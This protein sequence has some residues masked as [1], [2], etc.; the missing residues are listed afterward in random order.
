MFTVEQLEKP[1]TTNGSQNQ[2]HWHGHTVL[3]KPKLKAETL[4]DKTRKNQT[5]NSTAAEDL[6]NLIKQFASSFQ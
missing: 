2:V 1:L 6:C 3:N 5:R 4:G